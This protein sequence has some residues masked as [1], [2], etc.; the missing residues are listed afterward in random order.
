VFFLIADTDLALRAQGAH[1][2]PAMPSANARLWLQKSKGIFLGPCG[3]N[4]VCVCVCVFVG[5]GDLVFAAVG[6]WATS[7]R[8]WADLLAQSWHRD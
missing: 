6:T 1:C 2:M 5:F 4:F 7:Q 3:R 8:T